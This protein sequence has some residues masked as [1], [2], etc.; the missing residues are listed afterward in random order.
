[1]TQKKIKVAILFGGRSTEHNISLLS[2]KNVIEAI[3]HDIFE[4]ILIGIDKSGKWHLN[5]G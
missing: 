2:A 3:D 1:M 5:E 4:P